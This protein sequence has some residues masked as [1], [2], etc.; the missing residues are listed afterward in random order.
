[1]TD[2]IKIFR[3]LIM[4]EHQPLEMDAHNQHAEHKKTLGAGFVRVRS[5]MARGDNWKYNHQVC[6]HTGHYKH[7]D[8]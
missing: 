4:D 2:E 8:R 1:M 6:P 5:A 7:G 3:A